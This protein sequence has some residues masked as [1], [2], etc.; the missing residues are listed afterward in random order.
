MAEAQVHFRTDFH[1][2][3]TTLTVS[4]AVAIPYVHE[5]MASITKKTIG[6]TPYLLNVFQTT[7]VAP[8]V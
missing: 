7:K 3:L 6:F 4:R 2:R 1:S 5:V 8:K